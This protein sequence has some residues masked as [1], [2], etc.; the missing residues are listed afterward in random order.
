MV[1]GHLISSVTSLAVP[2]TLQEGFHLVNLQGSTENTASL[3]HWPKRI[4]PS[5]QGNARVRR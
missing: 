2:I 4:D 3:P 5:V 1:L